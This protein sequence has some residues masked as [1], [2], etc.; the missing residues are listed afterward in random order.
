MTTRE[1]VSE[2]LTA[3]WKL[4]R[5]VEGAKRMHAFDEEGEGPHSALLDMNDM[6]AFLCNGAKGAITGP[7]EKLRR[8]L[9]RFE[10]LAD[11]EEVGR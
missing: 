3:S 8:V 11:A 4:V 6:T 5:A 10:R 9:E 7:A 1:V 2:L